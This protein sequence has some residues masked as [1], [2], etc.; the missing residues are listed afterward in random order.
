MQ[1]CFANPYFISKKEISAKGMHYKSLEPI[2]LSYD[3]KYFAALERVKN[4]KKKYKGITRIL[5]IFR[6]ENKKLVKVDALDIP[7]FHRS[8]A[9][10]G[11]K[12]NKNEL[13][14]V[15]NHGTK[16][17][18]V[19]VE[20]MTLNTVFQHREGKAGFKG[21]SVIFSHGGKFYISGWRYDRKQYSKG[22][23]VAYIK[24]SKRGKTRFVKKI[25]I[26]N[27]FHKK[28]LKI[29]YVQSFCYISGEHFLFNV[30]NPKKRKRN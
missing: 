28:Y 6:F 24:T 30:V 8:H 3:G 15:G 4:I 12:R 7:I 22:N 19:D 20:K 26:S 18:K 11:S 13:M 27:L 1:V 5:R 25:D 23:E 21:D 2:N 29:G 16:Y 10:L 17:M 9:T 14:I